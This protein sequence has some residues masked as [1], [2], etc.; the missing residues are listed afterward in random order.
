MRWRRAGWVARPSQA[1]AILPDPPDS[2]LVRAILADMM[3]MQE[4]PKR[5]NGDRRQGERRVSDEAYAGEER[6]V[7]ER[8]KS[9]R[10]VR[11]T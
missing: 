1:W 10:R 8:R 3:I 11:V 5:R 4:T 6:R 9:Q 7:A 2:T